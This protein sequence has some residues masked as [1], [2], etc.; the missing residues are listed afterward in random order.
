MLTVVCSLWRAAERL[1]GM[2][3][4]VNEEDAVTASHNELVGAVVEEDGST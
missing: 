3:D 4:H 1:F 2:R